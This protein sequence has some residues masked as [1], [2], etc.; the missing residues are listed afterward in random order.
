MFKT[1]YTQMN[2]STDDASCYAPSSFCASSANMNL[3]DTA[4]AAVSLFF[5]ALTGLLRVRIIWPAAILTAG[6]RTEA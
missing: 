2:M 1:A 3:R 5:I 4:V 6:Y